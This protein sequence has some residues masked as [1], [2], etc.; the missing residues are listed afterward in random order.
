MRPAVLRAGA[1]ATLLLAALAA[2]GGP[3]ATPPATLR[4]DGL[5]TAPAG[6]YSEFLRFYDDGTV[7]AVTSSGTAA[8]VAGWL[9]ADFRR[10]MKGTYRVEGS[11]LVVNVAGPDGGVEFAGD[12]AG[13]VL[14]LARTD[15]TTG[16][17][18]LAEYGFEP[19][20]LR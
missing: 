19:V 3:G 13:S 11:R 6:E 18:A 16:R 20:P 10:C 2:C 7:L 8:D 4:L 12:L 1:S 5:Y 15:R 17:R 14:R 9:D